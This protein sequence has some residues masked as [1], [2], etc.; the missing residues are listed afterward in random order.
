MYLLVPVDELSPPSTVDE[1]TGI[2]TD[3]TVD[4]TVNSARGGGGSGGTEAT[5]PGY[6]GLWAGL[7]VGLVGAALVAL[8]CVLLR[9]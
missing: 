3:N 9:A 8:V 2:L 7:G 6:T 5:E 4:G 1:G